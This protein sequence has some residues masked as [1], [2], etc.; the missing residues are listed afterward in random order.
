[1]IWL[2]SKRGG[3]TLVEI[4]IVVA[5][6]GLLGVMAIPSFVKARETAQKNACI[7][8]LRILDSAKEQWG[9]ESMANTGATVTAAN[10]NS[11]IKG[12]TTNMYCPAEPTKTFA[13]S[14]T[15][16]VLGTDPACRIVAGTHVLP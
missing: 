8:N 5:I 10:V 3:F 1:M 14:Y 13:T 15:I 11:Y 2:K 7:N 16:G 9:I 4:M 6:I 12:T